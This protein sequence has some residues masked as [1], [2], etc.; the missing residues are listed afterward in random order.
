MSLEILTNKQSPLALE[1]AI[2]NQPESVYTGLV[3]RN[4]SFVNAQQGSY[5]PGQ[6]M[7]FLLPQQMLDLRSSYVEFQINVTAN[8]AVGLAMVGDIR[9]IFKRVVLKFG[10]KTFFDCGEF[11]VLQNLCNFSLDPNWFAYNGSTLVGAGNL[12]SRQ[13]LATQPTYVY[14][15]K[16]DLTSALG[17]IFDSVLPLHKISSQLEIDIY[18]APAA[19]VMSYTSITSPNIPTYTVVSPTFH[20]DFLGPDSYWNASYD[21]RVR[22][23]PGITYSFKSWEELTDT[24][25]LPIGQSSFQKVLTFKNSNVLGILFV[26]Q[27]ATDKTDFTVPGKM[28]NNNFNNLNGLRLKIGGVSYPQ[29]NITSAGDTLGRFLQMFKVPSDKPCFGAG[30]WTG[31]GFVAACPL[32]VYPYANQDSAVPNGIDTSIATSIILDVT[33]STPI[34][35]Q[36]QNLYIYALSE[37]TLQFLANGGVLWQQ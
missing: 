32:N 20:A 26:M 1:Q 3:S 30:F 13:A 17:S 14:A 15:C 29:D 33:F 5:N 34:S 22:E 12:A 18:L 23:N 6:M 27:N 9:S 28:N 25:I 8:T 11:G 19:E 16:M 4:S 35:G 36:N 31:T 10:S 24:S 7:Q 37:Q 21:K 2:S